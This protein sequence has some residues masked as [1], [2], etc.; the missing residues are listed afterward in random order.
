M[1]RVNNVTYPIHILTKA[2]YGWTVV[3]H[4]RTIHHPTLTTQKLGPRVPK[5]IIPGK[6]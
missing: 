5:S 4:F 6:Q 3:K 1:V 2:M